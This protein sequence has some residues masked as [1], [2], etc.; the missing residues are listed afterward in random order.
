MQHFYANIKKN[1]NQK[2]SNLYMNKK[3]INYINICNKE[4]AN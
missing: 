4:L 2:D 3:Q 1:K